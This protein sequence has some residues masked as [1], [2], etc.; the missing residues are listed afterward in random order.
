MRRAQC[1]Q[2]AAHSS[3]LVGVRSL[4]WH[5]IHALV[6][7]FCTGTSAMHWYVNN[8]LVPH[9][10]GTSLRCLVCRRRRWSCG[11]RGWALWSRRYGSRTAPPP[12]P[13]PTW[14]SCTASSSWPCCAA[15]T[16]CC[17]GAHVWGVLVA[18]R[19]GMTEVWERWAGAVRGRQAGSRR[20][21]CA[22]QAALGCACR[23][24]CPAG[25][26]WWMRG[27]GCRCACPAWGGATPFHAAQRPTRCWGAAATRRRWACWSPRCCPLPGEGR[28]LGLGFIWERVCA[29]A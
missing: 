3:L 5:P 21:A 23:P 2:A 26:C 6:P 18:V 13:A 24:R 14:H 8:A 1:C 17:S 29:G 15:W 28:E 7:Q 20:A 19:W 10:T 22:A 9:G 27:R 4:H 25:S 11:C 12:P 16:R